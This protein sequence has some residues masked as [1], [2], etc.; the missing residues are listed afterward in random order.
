MFCFVPSV[1]SGQWLQDDVGDINAGN[2][3]AIRFLLDQVGPADRT[4]AARL[5]LNDYLDAEGLLQKWLLPPGF[6]V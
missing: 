5:V 4:P 3:I 6:N 2:E 1:A